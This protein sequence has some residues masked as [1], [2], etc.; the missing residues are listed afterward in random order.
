MYKICCGILSFSIMDFSQNL[1]TLFH[2]GH[3]FCF[4]QFEYTGLLE[5]A[6]SAAGVSL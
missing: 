3:I 2:R 5:D 1:I 6:I 4:P